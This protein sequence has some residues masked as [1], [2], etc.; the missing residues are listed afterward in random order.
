MKFWQSNPY[1]VRESD[2]IKLAC[3]AKTAAL[4]PYT[5]AQENLPYRHT[6]NGSTPADSNQV[7]R[8]SE[9]QTQLNSSEALTKRTAFVL[10]F[11]DLYKSVHKNDAEQQPDAEITQKAIQFYQQIIL[12]NSYPNTPCNTFGAHAE[13][14]LK[15]KV[16]SDASL[17][18]D[19]YARY[20]S[21]F[22]TAGFALFMITALLAIL[23]FLLLAVAP[24][25]VN[26]QP[27]VML[28]IVDTVF[29]GVSLSMIISTAMMTLGSIM[30]GILSC[31]MGPD[32]TL[33]YCT[34]LPKDTRTQAD[35]LESI[36]TRLIVDAA[37]VVY[38]NTDGSFP[39]PQNPL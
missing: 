6:I 24:I 4:Y 8:S 20:T 35:F 39:S 7:Y 1:Q 14:E 18:H 2:L 29:I 34:Y 36:D 10:A 32:D 38:P 3:L 16:F 33:F 5:K 26:L 13:H 12:S 22:A 28:H 11:V 17:K 27:L 37:A 9:Y 31:C 21:Y 23:T 25:F 30:T 19:A 15:T